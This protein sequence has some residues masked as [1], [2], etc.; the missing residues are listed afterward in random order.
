MALLYLAA[1]FLLG[2]V[3]ALMI[4]AMFFVS[5]RAEDNEGKMCSETSRQKIT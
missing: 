3:S 4:M 5:K 1:G 2:G